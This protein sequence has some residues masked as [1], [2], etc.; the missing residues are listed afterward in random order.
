MQRAMADGGPPSMCGKC[1]GSAQGAAV[2]R[3]TVVGELPSMYGKS[4]GRAQ[5]SAVQRTTSQHLE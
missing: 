3:A 2:Q 4:S 5:S 1:I